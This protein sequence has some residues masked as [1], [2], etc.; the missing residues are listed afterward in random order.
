[1]G[2][3]I[4][5]VRRRGRMCKLIYTIVTQIAHFIGGCITAIAS[6]G[7]PLLSILLFL[8][9]IIYEVNEDWSLSDGAYKD[10]L[11][12]TLGLYIAAIFLLA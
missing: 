5:G 1:M 11:V 6:V 4:L 8:S 10:I 2:H 3:D 9:F 7:H 12:Y